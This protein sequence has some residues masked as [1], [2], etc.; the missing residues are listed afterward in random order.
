MVINGRSWGFPV[1]STSLKP[2]HWTMD[3]YVVIGK[4]ELGHRLSTRHVQ[5]I[6]SQH[7]LQR[8]MADK[9]SLRHVALLCVA[10]LLRKMG[11][12]L[13]IYSTTKLAQ[14]TSSRQAVLLPIRFYFS[15]S[16]WDSVFL[17]YADSHS[18]FLS[19][20]HSSHAPEIFHWNSCVSK[21]TWESHSE[22]PQLKPI[23]WGRNGNPK[24]SGGCLLEALGAFRVFQTIRT[25]VGFLKY[26]EISLVVDVVY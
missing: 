19:T 3:F 6:A 4:I 14:W 22:T 17:F 15:E 8:S 24:P 12:C 13:D 26:T 25:N 21:R 1:N 11:R 16:H 9:A 5:K 23:L 20:S 2:I 18:A 10:Q 7:K